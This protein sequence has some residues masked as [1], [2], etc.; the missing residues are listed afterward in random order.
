MENS[1]IYQALKGKKLTVLVDSWCWIEYLK[2]SD[3]GELTRDYIEGEERLLISVINVA[4][5]YKFLLSNRTIKESKEFLDFML[6]RSFVIPV[7]TQIAVEAAII[8]HEKKWGLADA[9]VAATAKLYKVKL[10]TGD[11]DFKKESDVIYF[12]N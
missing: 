12:G 1:G 11:S 4:E 6:K 10:I 5:V 3:K 8:K 9:I 2:G 7:I